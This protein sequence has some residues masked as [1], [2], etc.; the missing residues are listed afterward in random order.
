MKQSS[1]LTGLVAAAGL[2]ISASANASVIFDTGIGAPGTLDTHWTISAAIGTAPAGDPTIQAYPSVFPLV[3]G[4]WAP[5]IGV[6]QWITP[7]AN[8]GDSFD[9]GAN[10]F[11]TYTEQFLGT[12][13][14][15]IKGQYL[16]DNTVTTITLL[17]PLQVAVGGGDFKNPPSS[18]A[19]APLPSNGLYTLNFTVENFAQNGGNP[20]GL[21]VAVASVPE[22]STWAMMILGFLGLGFLGYRRSSKSSSST[23]RMA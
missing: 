18:F 23:F 9:P 16:S 20:T 10:G 14:S 1:L 17:S 22:A 15:V 12:A 13:G 7:T 8:P 5:P 3:P 19:F 11:Y 21:D 4:V 6:S 2:L